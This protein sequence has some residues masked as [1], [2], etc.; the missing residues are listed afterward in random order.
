LSA[1]A[2]SYAH[3][4]HR[5]CLRWAFGGWIAAINGSFFQGGPTNTTPLYGEMGGS[6]IL[7]GPN[8][9]GSSIFAARKP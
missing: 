9:M 8:Y 5:V 4:W 2:L 3:D 6:I 7:N 1:G